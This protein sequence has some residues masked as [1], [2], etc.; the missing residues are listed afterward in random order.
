MIISPFAGCACCSCS[1][2][3]LSWLLFSSLY[4]PSIL[5]LW[6]HLVLSDT[7]SACMAHTLPPSWLPFPQVTGVVGRA[8]LLSSIF[9]LGA[10]LMYTRCT[11]HRSK[12]GIAFTFFLTVCD[13]KIKK[14][15]S[16]S[17]AVCIILCLNASS[18]L[19]TNY[20]SISS[21]FLSGNILYQ[22]FHRSCAIFANRIVDS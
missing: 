14:L 12:T 2:S 16:W 21:W 10:F 18:P 3:L 13:L 1:Q 4:I 6:V 5:K 8:E 17:W 22:M 7:P 9:Y 19:L 20:V 15:C 11:G